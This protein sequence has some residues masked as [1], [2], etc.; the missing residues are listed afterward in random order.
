M[1]DRNMRDTQRRKYIEEKTLENLKF[2]E[3]DHESLFAIP[4]KPQENN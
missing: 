3:N 4:K 2:V 1:K